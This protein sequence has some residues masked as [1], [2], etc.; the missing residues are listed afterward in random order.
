MYINRQVGLRG[1][2]T[3]PRFYD[4]Q[5]ALSQAAWASTGFPADGTGNLNIWYLPAF[6][7]RAI[8]RKGADL[9]KCVKALIRTKTG[10]PDD[11]VLHKELYS[12]FSKI[13]ARHLETISIA[14]QAVMDK[15]AYNQTYDYFSSEGL[16]GS[17]AMATDDTALQMAIDHKLSEG[18]QPG[19]MK[20]L[21]LANEM[22]KTQAIDSNH[23]VVILS[24]AFYQ[25]IPWANLIDSDV[26]GEVTGNFPTSCGEK[27]LAAILYTV[28]HAVVS[29]LL[30][31]NNYE[32]TIL[33]YLFGI[34]QRLVL[35]LSKY[36]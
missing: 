9:G 36:Q 13:E 28:T 29:E 30:E 20:E 27:K 14:T 19:Q 35:L 32:T 6:A 23:V 1:G 25:S 10:L 3:F 26:A 33:S 11:P 17:L 7:A 24:E 18:L 4:V 2:Q 16:V 21:G 22:V 12:V 8:R 15:V 34:H 31:R 5:S